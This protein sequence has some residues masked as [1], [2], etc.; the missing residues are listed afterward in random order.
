MCPQ[1]DLPAVPVD[2]NSGL[3][4]TSMGLYYHTTADEKRCMFPTERTVV[5]VRDKRGITRAGSSCTSPEAR[6][7]IVHP[8][9]R[10]DHLLR[11]RR[12]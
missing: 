8:P 9:G 1:R 6:L 4:A 7:G 3:S 5:D 10:L 12:L 11:A 2:Y